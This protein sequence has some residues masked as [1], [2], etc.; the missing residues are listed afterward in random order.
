MCMLHLQMPSSLNI[1]QE[2][3]EVLEWE[4]SDYINDKGFQIQICMVENYIKA[5]K[6]KDYIKI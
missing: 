3:L 1:V 4:P 2:L 5:F 6:F